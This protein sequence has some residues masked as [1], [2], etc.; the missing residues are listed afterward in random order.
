MNDH[1]LNVPCRFSRTRPVVRSCTSW[2]IA[3]VKQAFYNL[4]VLLIC[5]LRRLVHL[6]RETVTAAA[7]KST[8]L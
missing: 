5:F 6:G 3:Q 2:P 4:V 1:E 7:T 8:V